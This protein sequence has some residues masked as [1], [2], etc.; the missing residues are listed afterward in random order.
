MKKGWITV[1]LGEL[2]RIEKGVSPTMKTEPG[3]F[4]LVVTAAYRRTSVDFQFSESAACI[5][6]VSSTGHGNAAIHRIHYEEGNFALANLLVAAIPK[7]RS[8]LDAKFLWRYLS[9]VKDTVLVP[10]MQGTAN[11]TLKPVDLHGV[12]VMLPPLTEQQRIVAHL[13]AIETRFSGVQKLREE[14]ETELLATLRSTFH[15]IESESDWVELG[16]VAPLTRRE[17]EINPDQTYTEYGIKS[18]YKGIFLRRKM[19]GAEYTWQKLFWL[20]EGDVVFSNIMAWEKAIGFA[21]PEMDGW[22]GNHRMLICEPR[23][24]KVVPEWLYFYFT[25]TRGFDEI[26]KASPGTAARN[27]TLRPVNLLKIPVPVPPLEKQRE[28]KKLMDLRAA[29]QRES[30]RSLERIS[31]TLPSL[32]D[33]IF[34]P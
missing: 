2:C 19:K 23:Q 17:L 10:L 25:T 3:E 32:L 12:D 24:E 4:P 1:S 33:R 20:K 28:F 13:D 34:K 5:P 6:I 16:D 22:V 27:K 8:I 18:F 9:V 7:D 31:A 11:V 15:R 26:L 30:N 14:Q 29:I 21:G